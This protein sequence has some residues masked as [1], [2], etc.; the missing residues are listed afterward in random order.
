MQA[1]AASSTQIDLTWDDNSSDETGFSIEWS[2]DGSSG[3]AVAGTVAAGETTF[4]DTDLTP[5]TPYYYRV[6][7]TGAGAPSGYSNTATATTDPPPPPADPSN[8]QAAAASSTQIDLTWDDNS[9]DETGFSIEWSADGSSGWAVAGTVAAGETTFSD[10]DLTP[11]TPYYYRVQATGA[12]APSGYSNTATAT[13]DPPPPPADPSNLQ[14]A[15]ASST[16]IDLTWDDNSSD[17][18]GFSI[19]WSADG[20]SGWAVA[21][22]VAAGETTFSDTDLT[23][24]TPYYYRVQ[25]T[26][27]GAPS[28]YSNTATATTSATTPPSTAPRW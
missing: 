11:S 19:E 2:A 1:A 21:G 23:P 25:A 3:W 7:A 4:S 15:A 14:A 24:S 5:S 10:T 13:T 18:T 22:T 20:S 26:G 8:L 16:Q 17:E 6:Q 27:A 12:G 9:S 28:G